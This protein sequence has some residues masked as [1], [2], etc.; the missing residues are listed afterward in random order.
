MSVSTVYYINAMATKGRPTKYTEDLGTEICCR[1]ANGESLRSICRDSKMPSRPTVLTWLLDTKK[2]DFLDQYEASRNIGISELF[3]QLIDI[4][5]TGEDVARD[6]LRVDTRKWYL[7]KVL[8]KVYGD[9]IDLTTDGKE[10][11][12]PIIQL[13]VQPNN[14]N[15]QDNSTQ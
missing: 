6:R 11:P 4:A 2:K 10:L 15:E 9:K 12:S 3:D 8:P 1:L 7:S 5:D 13:N 14:S